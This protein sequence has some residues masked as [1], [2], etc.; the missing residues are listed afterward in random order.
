MKVDTPR[1]ASH[2]AL[3]K[4]VAMLQ[5]PH[6]PTRG[7][8]WHAGPGG[9]RS[10]GQFCSCCPRADF[11]GHATPILSHAFA[12]SGLGSPRAN[13]GVPT[14]GCPQLRSFGHGPRRSGLGLPGSTPL[15]GEAPGA[16][17]S[18]A[19]LGFSAAFGGASFALSWGLPTVS[20]RR[21]AVSLAASR[22]PFCG[23]CGPSS[24]ALGK[25]RCLSPC[26]GAP[27]EVLRAPWHLPATTSAAQR[28]HP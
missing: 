12:R 15:A 5:L 9:S 19:A 28:I 3:R 24:V 14:G 26:I 23:S 21:S 2:A 17:R 22:G 20:L 6:G 18:W 16:Y 25:Q 7:F 4:P 10:D 11:R 13:P 27:S 1:R 8:D